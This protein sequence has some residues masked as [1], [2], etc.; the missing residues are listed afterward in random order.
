M[1]DQRWG[2]FLR[3]LCALM[4][5]TASFGSVW[6]AGNNRGSDGGEK[7][8]RRGEGRDWDSYRGRKEIKD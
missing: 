6:R 8:S 5:T 2:S 4:Q 1:E 7:K 3:A